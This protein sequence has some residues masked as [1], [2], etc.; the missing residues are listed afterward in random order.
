MII[1]SATFRRQPSSGYFMAFC[2]G[3]GWIEVGKDLPELQKRAAVHD[4]DWQA[5][6]VD[7]EWSPA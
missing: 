4:L 1:H 7:P 6:E 3:C 2:G 5:V